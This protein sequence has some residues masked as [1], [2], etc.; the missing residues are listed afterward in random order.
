MALSF[1]QKQTKP[2]NKQEEKLL[3]ESALDCIVKIWGNFKSGLHYLKQ[4]K[5][6][7]L[8]IYKHN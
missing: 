2:L 3:F 6:Q 1:F 5:Y 8:N 4:N 7:F